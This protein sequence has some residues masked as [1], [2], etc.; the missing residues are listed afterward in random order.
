MFSA[1]N[2]R[3]GRIPSEKE[4]IPHLRITRGESRFG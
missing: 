2:V 3:S 1:T 4:L